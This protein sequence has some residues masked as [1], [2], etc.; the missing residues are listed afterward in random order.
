MS[1][2]RWLRADPTPSW[3]HPPRGR[4]VDLALL[5]A[6]VALFV[7]MVALEKFESIPYH[8][9]FVLFA[10]SYGFRLWSATATAVLLAL[11]SVSTGLV[12][13]RRYLDAHIGVE[14]LAEIVLMP[15]IL[16]AMVWHARRG[17]AMRREIRE[18]A[19]REARQ[20]AREEEL[21][22][23]VSHAMRTPLTI[24]R[25]HLELIREVSTDA[26]ID[27]D[28]EIAVEELDRLERL[29]LRLLT[30]AKVEQPNG[31]VLRHED[32]SAFVL[33]QARR[34][35]TAVERDWRLEID[36]PSWAR[37]DRDDLVVAFDA[38][39]ENAVK[40]TSDGDVVRL[41]CHRR[42]GWV[43]VGVAD[44]GPGIALEHRQRALD[45]FW[46]HRVGSERSGSGLGLACAHSV[47]AAH[48]GDVIIASSTEGGAFVGLRLPVSRPA[49][50]GGHSSGRPR[51]QLAAL[52]S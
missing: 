11:L 14:E 8:L 9:M 22:R 50:D 32:I 23:D 44:S 7:A 26:T 13:L 38:L 51:T 24:A 35:S 39:A 47:A 3:P 21:L 46:S 30:I 49:P 28:T 43:T 5:A 52:P 18:G 34:W 31:V 20:L 1:A 2:M 29:S 19:A 33:E 17:D 42:D 6:A 48:G 41:V 16:A 4:W 25:G 45:R 37:I 40:V 10:V 15:A 27:E 12:L 36:S